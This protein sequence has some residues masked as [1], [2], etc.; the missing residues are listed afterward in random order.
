MEVAGVSAEHMLTCLQVTNSTL[1][2]PVLSVH[3][4]E[5]QCQ[6][7]FRSSKILFFSLKLCSVMHVVDIT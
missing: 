2:S 7:K 1:Y 5:V 4:V 3:T 6:N